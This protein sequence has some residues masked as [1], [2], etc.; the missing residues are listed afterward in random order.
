M[1]HPRVLAAT[2]AVAA[3]GLAGCGLFDAPDTPATT[4]E[5][6]GGYTPE[7]TYTV[8]ST[9]TRTREIEPTDSRATDRATAPAT[10][11]VSGGPAAATTTE[12]SVQWPSPPYEAGPGYRWVINGPFGTG[13]SSNCIQIAD[14]EYQRGGS[15]DYTECFRMPDGWYY[16]SYRGAG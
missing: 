15:D 13:T 11:T 10:P 3:L 9:H 4:P 7:T 16:Y 1:K 6:M 5:G 14:S 12:Q 2:T 8:T